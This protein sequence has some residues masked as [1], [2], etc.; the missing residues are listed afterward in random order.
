MAEPTKFQQ[1]NAAK[2]LRVQLHSHYMR[3]RVI[4]EMENPASPNEMD[5]SYVQMERQKTLQLATDFELFGE[6]VAI[7]L[8]TEPDFQFVENDSCATGACD[9]APPGWSK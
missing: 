6:R 9:F 5:G 7:A 1:E 3:E 2:T 8:M 4:I